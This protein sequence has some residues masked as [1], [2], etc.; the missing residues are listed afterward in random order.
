[1]EEQEQ[2]EELF[3][4]YLLYINTLDYLTNATRARILCLSLR[5]HLNPTTA[6][7]GVQQIQEITLI[8][9]LIR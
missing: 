7:W 5:P 3:N 8:S 9:C 2:D 1:M 4:V 6:R